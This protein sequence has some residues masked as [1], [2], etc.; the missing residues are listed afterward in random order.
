MSCSSRTDIFL[1]RVYES[2]QEMNIGKD[3]RR[4]RRPFGNE[5]LSKHQRSRLKL[6][7][8]VFALL[9]MRNFIIYYFNKEVLEFLKI[10][11]LELVSVATG[12][13]I[14]HL[15]GSKPLSSFLRHTR[16]S[17][18]SSQGMHANSRTIPG[19][20]LVNFDEAER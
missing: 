3:K 4:H 14:S 19:K 10:L 12:I 2:V 17:L 20:L 7:P 1:K 15:K 6:L 16:P 18:L 11:F 9:P 13:E 8:R 5:A